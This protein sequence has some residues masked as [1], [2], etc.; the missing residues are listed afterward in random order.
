M[1]HFQLGISLLFAALAVN[2]FAQD[3][4]GFKDDYRTDFEDTAKQLVQ[5]AQAMPAEKYGWRPGEGVRS[6]SEV[7]VHIAA[8]NFLLLS[9]TGVK[10]PSEYYPTNLD[11]KDPRA[12]IK[13]NSELEKKITSKADVVKMLQASLDA[14][15]ENFAK[16]TAADLDRQLDF[17]GEKTTVRRI[18][19]RMF[20]HC[21][22][23]MGQ[24]VAYARM[25]GVVPPWSHPA[26]KEK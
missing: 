13:Q 12:L 4:N 5:L 22:E 8:G 11:P 14:L 1:K 25:N 18:Y 16:T 3:V 2:V 26:P 21:N 7:Y 19:L 15:Q 6:V 20:A 9:L 17:F 24:S 10:L 23:H